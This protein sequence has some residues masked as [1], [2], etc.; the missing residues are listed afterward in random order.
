MRTKFFLSALVLLFVCS[1]SYAKIRR[2]GY[3]GPKITGTDYADLQTAHDDAAAKDTIM[4]YPGAW[5]SVFISKKL[6]II[7][8]GYFLTGAGANTGLQ[9][10]T[11]TVSADIIL[12]TGADS[13]IVEGVDNL[14]LSAIT[15]VNKVIVRRCRG[16]IYYNDSNLSDWQISQCYLDNFQNNPYI[17]TWGSIINFNFSNCWIAAFSMITNNHSGQLNNNVINFANF[18]TG[19][20]VVKN[21]IINQYHFNDLNCVYQNCIGQENYPLPTGNGNQTIPLADM[22]D[23]VYVGGATQGSYSND[24]R[25]VL[26]AGSPAIGAGVG[27]VDC[28][29]FGGTNPYKL[30]GIPR[31][32]AV[33]KLTAPTNTTSTN[34]Y[35]ITFST[36]SNN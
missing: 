26:K 18:G 25:W 2:V 10:I 12:Q 31:I 28:G 3:T 29:M 36:R 17:S 5:G 19:A 33:Y 27:G 4:L 32:P 35:T 9:N 24:G 1:M 13:C 23:N 6:V 11:G 22:A 8:P 30:S 7:G 20:F 34:P 14:I 16:N 15:V 21:T